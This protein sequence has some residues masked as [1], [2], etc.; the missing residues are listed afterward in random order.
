MGDSPTGI[1]LISWFL[2]LVSKRV[3]VQP[4]TILSNLSLLVSPIP[5]D[6]LKSANQ[7]VAYPL[8]AIGHVPVDDAA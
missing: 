4:T 1:C 5:L 8:A 2:Y 6:R 7:L 3:V